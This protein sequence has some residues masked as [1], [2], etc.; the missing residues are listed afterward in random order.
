MPSDLLH[1]RQMADVAEQILAMCSKDLIS[2]E[3]NTMLL[4]IRNLYVLV[5]MSAK[6]KY[7]NLCVMELI[8]ST[9]Q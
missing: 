1:K 9:K 7:L 3:A 6:L 8:L 2:T 4:A 5:M